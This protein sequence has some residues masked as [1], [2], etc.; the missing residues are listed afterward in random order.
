MGHVPPGFRTFR[1]HII[2]EGIV[3][4]KEQ[5]EKRQASHEANRDK[6]RAYDRQR[7]EQEVMTLGLEELAKKARDYY[8]EHAE[9]IAA[10][11]KARKEE[12]KSLRVPEGEA[13]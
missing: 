3:H 5:N 10:R 1:F 4:R 8:H 13:R 6:E 12:K 9:Q 7:Y 2:G 11:R